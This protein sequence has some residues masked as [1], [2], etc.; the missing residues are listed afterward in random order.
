V[1]DWIFAGNYAHSLD[2]KSRV[3]LPAKFRER[4][5][6]EVVIAPHPD[7][8]ISVWSMAGFAK[9]ANDQQLQ[10][11]TDAEVRKFVRFQLGNAS[12]ENVD[13]Q[14]RVVIKPALRQWAGLEKEVLISGAFDHAE[15]WRPDLWNELNAAMADDFANLDG[16]IGNYFPSHNSMS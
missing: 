12:T 10:R 6:E 9:F 2:D 4:L 11:S 13:R 8:C 3:F 1:A 16:P 15:I 14:G 5:T 7:H